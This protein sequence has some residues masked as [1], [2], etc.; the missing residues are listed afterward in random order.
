MPALFGALA[1]QDAGF[2]GLVPHT[3]AD[4]E[5]HDGKNPLISAVFAVRRRDKRI[6]TPLLNSNFLCVISVST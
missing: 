1:G 6:L 2:V 3:G 5:G 4:E